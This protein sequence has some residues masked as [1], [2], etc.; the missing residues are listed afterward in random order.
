MASV[1]PVGRPVH[2]VEAI[3]YFTSKARV[4]TNTWTDL[5]HDAHTRAF[6]VAGAT[7]DA[8]LADFQESLT[9]A[10]AQGGT[11]ADF[12]KD[13]DRI[14]AKHGWSYRGGRGWRTQV[15]FNTNVRMAYSAGRWQQ[16]QRLK[17]SR[18]WLRYVAVMDAQTRPEHAGWHDT[19]LP[20]DDPWWT[21][22]WPPNGWNCRCSQQSLS[23]SDLKRYGLKPTPAPPVKMEARKIRVPDGS[24]ET[25]MTPAGIDTGFGYNPG[26]AWLNIVPRQAALPLPSPPAP[27]PANPLPPLPSRP[28]TPPPPRLPRGLADEDYANAFLGEFGGGVGRPVMWRDPGGTRLTLSEELFK[29]YTGNWKIQKYGREQY[30]PMLAAALRDPDEIWLL[31]T[32]VA[33]PGQPPIWT[34]RRRY[35]R[36]FDDKPNMGSLAIFEW[37]W[38]GWDGVTNFPPTSASQVERQ[39]EGVLLYRRS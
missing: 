26:G 28:L 29:D 39:R 13:F 30:L 18:P 23:D 19:V 4:P 17:E 34:L 22:H 35:I 1:D 9:R 36:R 14:V 12:R 20:V 10:I 16:A 38:K 15:I 24:A 25:V 37:T 33:V 6:T 11:L 7:S 31:W 8:L 5:L 2:F 27:P 21:T 32:N 3:D